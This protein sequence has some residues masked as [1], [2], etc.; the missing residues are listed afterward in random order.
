MTITQQSNL[1]SASMPGHLFTKTIQLNASAAKVWAALTTPELM[2]QW[3]AE[4]GTEIEI[5][6]D[7][8]VGSSMVIRG[9]LHRINFVNTGTVLQ[10]D[11]DLALQYTHLSSLSRLPDQ[12]QS[13]SV[14]TFQLAAT[15]YQT[16]LTL[17]LHNFPTEAIYKHLAFY[18][19]VALEIFRKKVEQQ[20]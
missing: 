13:Y 7:W 16:R 12:P 11:P 4:P 2:R 3:M 9:T 15:E 17:T 18:W 20:V 10:F 19:N 6:T 8:K 14:V 1:A 5:I